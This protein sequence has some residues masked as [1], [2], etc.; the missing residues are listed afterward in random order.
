MNTTTKVVLVALAAG[1]LGVVASLLTS[2]AGPLW[3]T[4]VGQRALN[5]AM[6][7]SAPPVPEGVEVA[8]RGE[9]VPDFALRGL[10]RSRVTVPA[11]YAGRPVLINVWASW[12]G[13]CVKEMP[14]LQAFSKEQ[15]GN[16]VQVVGIALDDVDAVRAFVDRTGVTYPILVD[17]PGPADA[18]VRLGNPKGVLPYSVLVSADGRLLKQRIGPFEEGE[19]A[20]WAKD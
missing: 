12:C 15:A 16:G 5:S 17:T 11:Q 3:R 2:G 6:Q 20:G 8:E 19:I 7:A 9:R 4:E 18:G 13:P 10:D 14:A 1:A